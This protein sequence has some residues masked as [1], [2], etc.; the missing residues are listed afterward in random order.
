MSPNSPEV[1]DLTNQDEG[2]ASAARA[3]TPNRPTKR[4]R[5]S[6]RLEV[7]REH[8]EDTKKKSKSGRSVGEDGDDEAFGDDDNTPKYEGNHTNGYFEVDEVLDRRTRKYGSESAGLRH[9]V[10]YFVSWKIPSG[11]S[12]DE[13]DYEPSWLIAENLDQNSL[14]AAFR[15]FPMDADPD[16]DKDAKMKSKEEEEKDQVEHF[17][18]LE[19][20]FSDDDEEEEEEDEENDGDKEGI[21]SDDMQEYEEEEG[22]SKA[23]AAKY[24]G[25]SHLED[26]D[27]DSPG[28]VE[29][30]L[31]RRTYRVGQS[32]F[33]GPDKNII[34]TISMIQPIPRKA[35]CHKYMQIKKSFVCPEGQEGSYILMSEDVTLELSLLRLPCKSMFKKF[36]MKYIQEDEK[37]RSFAYFNERGKIRHHPTGRPATLDMYAGAGG[38][39]LG[40]EKYFNVKWVVDNNH[41]AAATLRANKPNSDAQIYTEDAKVFL[42][43]SVQG[44]PCY[45]APGE[46]DHIHASPPC[47]GVSRANRNGG[48]DDMQNNKQTLLF[49]KAI[50]HFRPKTASFENVPGLVLE[51]HKWYLQSVVASL[52]QLSYQVRVKILTSSSYGDPQKRRRLILVAARSDCLLPTMPTPTHGPELLPIKTCKDALQMF[53]Q[54]DPASSKSSGTVLIDNAIVFNHIAPR[55]KYDT[56]QD[57]ELI[58]DEPSRTILARSRPHLHYSGDRYISV[59]EAACLQ[60]FPTTHRFFGSLS[61]QYSQVGN[62]VPVKLATAIARSVAIVHGCAV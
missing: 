40:L 34:Y 14:A 58:E 50:K 31:N 43:K 20:D 27:Y 9:V 2:A 41:L 23:N 33:S 52:L 32:Y 3:I 26:S 56:E 15:Q 19:D 47:K 60:S 61:S 7:L 38:M 57:Y 8:G 46:V 35:K 49:F 53:E 1:I 11:Y 54:H 62:A 4:V 13:S 48:K 30:C 17:L 45:P 59:R 29:L 16:H 25:V 51:D 36:P 44:N 28:T 6:R 22:G 10:E 55:H 42:K 5:A 12:G 37:Q 39:S 24:P 21:S 18:D